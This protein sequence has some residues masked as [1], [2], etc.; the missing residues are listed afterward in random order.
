MCAAIAPWGITCHVAHCYS[1]LVSQVERTIDWSPHLATFIVFSGSLKARAQEG[2]FQVI[3]SLNLVS[4]GY[5]E[6]YVSSIRK[7][8][9]KHW[10]AIKDNHRWLYFGKGFEL[11]WLATQKTFLMHDNCVFVRLFWGIYQPKGHNIM[12]GVDTGTCMY[13]SVYKWIHIYIYICRQTFEY[14]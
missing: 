8:T 9:V 14:A 2:Q 11:P 7:L 1:S 5:K 12:Q 10:E 3:S 6:C 13:M 4:A